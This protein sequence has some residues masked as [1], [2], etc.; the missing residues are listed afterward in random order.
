MTQTGTNKT[1]IVSCITIH[2]PYAQLSSSLFKLDGTGKYI[3]YQEHDKG[4]VY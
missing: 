4:I 2:N 3:V 1:I